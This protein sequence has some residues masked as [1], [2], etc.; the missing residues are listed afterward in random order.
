MHGLSTI[1]RMNN[2][3]PAYDWPKTICMGIGLGLSFCLALLMICLLADSPTP[4]HPVC[5]LIGVWVLM[6][7][8]CMVMGVAEDT[9]KWINKRLKYRR[10]VARKILS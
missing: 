7:V 8:G 1:H 3:A 9:A 6:F 2:P 5:V 4:M 10:A